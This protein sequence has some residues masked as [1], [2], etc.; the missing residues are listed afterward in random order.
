MTLAQYKAV[1]LDMDGVLYRGHDRL[2]GADTLIDFCAQQGIKAACITNNATMTPAQ[3]AQ[4]LA[5]MGITFPAEHIINSAVATRLWLAGQAPQGTGIYC[6]GMN[7]LRDALF[8]DGYFVFDDQQPAFVVVGLDTEVT[9]AKL[10]QAT[11]LIRNGARF[12]GTNPDVTLPMPEGLVPGAGSLLALLSATTDQQ[13]FVIGKPGPTMFHIA[14]QLLDITPAETLTIG[15]RL[16][17]DVAGAV[18]AG[19]TAGM[20]LTGVVTRADVEASPLKPDLLYDDL[21]SLLADWRRD[22]GIA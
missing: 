3:F 6:I 22:L 10:R 9:Y 12:I 18:A 13:P 16:D 15:D 4:K 5:G 11:L 17:T 19:L 21:P 8:G 14:M 20:V 7:G 2:A 1:L